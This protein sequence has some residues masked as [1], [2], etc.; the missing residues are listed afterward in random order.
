VADMNQDGVPDLWLLGKTYNVQTFQYDR[1]EVE[2]VHGAAGTGPYHFNKA[3]TATT[4]ITCNLDGFCHKID[5]AKPLTESGWFPTGKADGA[6]PA[7]LGDFNGDGLVDIAM[8]P[9][10][11]INAP[12]GVS[13]IHFYINSGKKADQITSIDTGLDTNG[14][15]VPDGAHVGITYAPISDPAVYRRARRSVA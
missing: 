8:V 11:E 10:F 13:K 1:K 15:S 4:P 6:I 2:L 3:G 5:A 7:A 14:D 12:S 9:S